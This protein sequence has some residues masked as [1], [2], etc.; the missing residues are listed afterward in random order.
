MN[1]TRFA[2]GFLTF[3]GAH[4]IEATLWQ[5]WFGGAHLPWFLNS[6]RAVA[7]TMSGMFV[8]SMIATARS[9]R[10]VAQ[11]LHVAAGGV[12]AMA[13][14]LLVTGQGTLFPMVLAIGSGLVI[15]SSVIG[16]WVGGAVSRRR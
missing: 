12:T 14:V 13:V 2:L 16:A 10:P 6:G 15:V 3:I 7:F 8:V 9:D 4:V 11:G 1:W 5:R